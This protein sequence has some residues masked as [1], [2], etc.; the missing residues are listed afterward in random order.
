MARARGGRRRFADHQARRREAAR[1]AAPSQEPRPEV[2]ILAE[3][4]TLCHTPG[5]AHIVTRAIV[6]D[7]FVFYKDEMKPEDMAHL[8]GFKR[9][10][11][12]EI[13]TLIG[14][15]IQAGP[16]V[17]GE[18]SVNLQDLLVKVEAV[19]EELH[20]S[21]NLPLFGGGLDN[22]LAASETGE[23]LREPIFYS[24]ESAFQFQYRD[25]AIPK[26]HPDNGWLKANRGFSIEQAADVLDAFV[27]LMEVQVIQRWKAFDPNDPASWSLLPGFI[28][29]RADVVERSGI[30]PGRVDAVIAAFSTPLGSNE[31]FVALNDYNLATAAPLIGLG[32]DRYAVLQHY[33]PVEALYE[34]PMYWMFADKA[35]RDTASANRGEFTEAITYQRL[36]D[37]FGDEN[38]HRGLNL[39]RAKGDRIGEIDILVEFAGRV[40]LVQAKSKRLT[41]AARQGN[42]GNLRADFKAAVQD[43]YDQALLCAEALLD[44]AIEISRADGARVTLKHPPQAIYPICLVSDHYPSLVAQTDRFLAKRALDQVA[45]PIVTDIFALDALCELLDRPI[46]FIGYCEL[47]DR[48]SERLIYSHELVLLACHVRQNLWID[49]KFGGMMLEDNITGP[50]EIAMLARRRGIPGERTPRGP[51]TAFVGTPF[52]GMLRRIEAQPEPPLVDLALFMLEASGNSIKAY[53]DGV[54]LITAQA[55]NDMSKHDFSLAMGGEGL[56]V[57]TSYEGPREVR[58]SLEMHVEARKYACRA[59]RWFGLFLDPADGLPQVGLILKFPWEEDPLRAELAGHLPNE[60]PRIALPAS[61]DGLVRARPRRRLGRNDRCFCGSGLKFKKCCGQ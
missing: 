13:A 24:G 44:S 37:V 16:E 38:V 40:L 19:L 9:L 20:H 41:I 32:E 26:Y 34:A 55:R 33:A 56:T 47:R 31:E 35:Y 12:T 59:D 2:E 57:H 46:R 60:S 42:E 7:N 27:D 14:Y 25:F 23:A 50:I 39:D 22:F 48:F 10:I 54:K 28:V 49:D 6:R 17:F 30:E 15:M 29:A 51:L 4:R 1:E 3:L 36:V 11:R 45:Q 53:N 18:P 58:E 43:A 21:L 5:F 61:L 8:F 52:E